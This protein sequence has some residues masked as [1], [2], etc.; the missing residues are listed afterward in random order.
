MNANDPFIK[1][2]IDINQPMEKNPCRFST[3]AL[4]LQGARK[5]SGR[6]F[7]TGVY[8]M[9]ELNEQNFIDGTYQSFQFTGLI[10]YLIF[11]EQI[12][13]VFRKKDVKIDK[14]DNAIKIALRSF[15]LLPNEKIQAINFLR[16]SFVHNYGLV[17]YDKKR[18]NLPKYKFC[19]SIERNIEIVKLPLV[20][21]DG[22]F[23][24]KSDETTTEIY[25]IDLMDLIEGVYSNLKK[26]LDRDSVG[27]L[28]EIAEI[29]SR[30]TIIN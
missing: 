22:N 19:L 25:I 6:N 3:I 11:L 14:N 7:Y 20:D 24:D 8:E 17:C 29:K 15:S 13:T 26:E 16:H 12:G 27:V 23:S 2:L 5:L 9:D 18:P 10:N 1:S 28:P 21:W 30:F 4:L